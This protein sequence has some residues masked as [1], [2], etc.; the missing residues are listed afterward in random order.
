MQEVIEALNDRIKS[1][2]FGYSILAFFA[3]NWR[4]IF[5]L[6]ATK[7]TPEERILAFDSKS[8]LLSLFV[9]PLLV[10]AIVAIASPWLK[11]AFTRLAKKPIGLFDSAQLEIENDRLEK[12]ANYEYRSAKLAA[13]REKELIQR[14]QRDEEIAN[15]EDQETQE[16]LKNKIHSVRKL[17]DLPFPATEILKTAAMTDDGQIHK[18]QTIGGQFFSVGEVD[19]GKQGAKQFA[20]YESGLRRLIHEGLVN[21]E[22]D[23]GEL[24][25]LTHEGWEYA[26]ML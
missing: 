22:G 11:Y 26:E 7:G 18:I 16:K 19:F 8:G 10:G 15:I 24:F 25:L 4:A 17:R 9:Y 23:K 6:I 21:P 20:E 3:L 1:P 13:E 2:Y 5:L 14:A 12:K